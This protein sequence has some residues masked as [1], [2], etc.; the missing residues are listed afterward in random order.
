MKRANC[1]TLLGVLSL[2]PAAAAAQDTSKWVCKLCRFETGTS[3]SVEAGAGHVSDSSAK[4]GEYNGLNQEG[5][6]LIGGAALRHRGADGTYWD[7]RA[8]ELGLDTRS[9]EIDGGRQGAYGVGVRYEELPHF[10]SDSAQT[11]FLGTGGASLTLPAG[12]PQSTTAQMPLAS[13]LR[14][15]DIETKRKRLGVGVSWLPQAGW[16]ST[17]GF[18]HE[19]REGTKRTAGAFFTNAAQLIEPVDYQTDQ[20]DAGASYAGRRLQATLAYY[21]SRFAN[22]HDALTW[23]NPFSMPAFPGATA[24]QL[25]LPPDNQ[26]HQVSASLGYQLSERTR[27]SADIA[28]G[29]MTQNEGYLA[30]T[31]NGT[32]VVP[33][34]PRGSLEGRVDILNAGLKVSSALTERLLVN[35]SYARD[36]RDNQTP[37]ATYAWVS[38]DMFLATP[39][40]NL[41]YSFTRD[42][43]KLS[44][45]YRFAPRLRASVGADHERFSRTFQEVERTRENTIW[46]RAKARAL[47]S[48]EL[49]FKLAHGE[50]RH[51]GYQAP[52]GVTPPENA[53]LRKYNMANR[54]RDSAGLRADLAATERISIGLGADT[55][56]DN[57]YDSPIG[58]REA[59]RASLSGDVSFM[60]SEETSLNAFASRETIHSEQAG[61]QSFSAPDWTAENHDTADVLGIGVRQ[62]VLKDRLDFGADYTITQTRGKTRVATGAAEPAFPDFTTRRDTYRLY[63][64]YRFDRKLSLRGGYWYERY[65]SADWMLDGVTPATIPN[66][67]TLGEQ[68]PK[69]R[70]NVFY[71]SLRYA[72]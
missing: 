37:Q 32:L 59:Q 16:K 35:A 60:L 65:R 23:Q 25:A 10:M 52:A 34:L 24:G 1:L 15:V 47:D 28:W 21:G 27:A 2:A 66:V 58:L 8:S 68:P 36:E 71:A 11:P 69:Y 53:L 14:T 63:A 64:T 57:Y 50:R 67:L 70:V 33:P 29:R 62:V 56:K 12:Y 17:L 5:A 41:P 22:A 48:L 43:V 18:R 45:D 3:A 40:T 49:T 31:L 13:T 20:I 30:P 39:R 44:G 51:D 26:F 38:T 55:S 19:S 42:L 7:A 54:D 4:F 9:A 72:F 6:Y 46:G 61:S